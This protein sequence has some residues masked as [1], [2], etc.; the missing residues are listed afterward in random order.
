M[1]A[2]KKNLQALFHSKL[3]NFTI[4]FPH[5]HK[6]QYLNENLKALSTLPQI[7]RKLNTSSQNLFFDA[8]FPGIK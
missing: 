2:N 3:Q 7:K 5:F 6:V 8:K 1:T 4:N